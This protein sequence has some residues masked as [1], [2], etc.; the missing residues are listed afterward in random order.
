GKFDEGWDVIRQRRIRRM[1][2]LGLI[3]DRWL[4]SERDENIELWDSLSQQQ[5][6]FLLPM[7]EV[8]A[9]MIDRLDQNIGRLVENLKANN[10]LENTLIMFFSDNGACPYNRLRGKGTKV[11]PGGPESDYAYDARWANMC[12]APL[13]LYKQYAHHGG[14]LTPMIV[15]WPKGIQTGGQVIR[16]PGHLVDI[17]PTILDAADS[18]YPKTNRREPIPKMQGVSLLPLF[19]GANTQ[20]RPPIFWEFSGHHAIRDGDWKLVAQ[21]GQDWELFNVSQD[22]CETKNLAASHAEI[23]SRMQQQYND[24]AKRVSAKQHQRCK[25]MKPNKQSQLFDLKALLQ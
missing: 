14:T 13:R 21:R 5:K 1:L 23:V 6:D 2:S 18:S 9:G 24:W 7:M 10:E 4:L 12:N 8:Y 15:H 17:M 25:A 20:T 19:Q 16:S 22:P 3:D 11:P